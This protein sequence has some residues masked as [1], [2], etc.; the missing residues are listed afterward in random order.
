MFIVSW[1]PQQLGNPGGLGVARK[2]YSASPVFYRVFDGGSMI[3]FR[4]R[5][6]VKSQFEVETIQT[7]SGPSGSEMF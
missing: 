2:A 3:S 6:L 1:V 5:S 7:R 4:L